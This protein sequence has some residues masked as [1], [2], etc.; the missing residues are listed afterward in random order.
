MQHSSADMSPDVARDKG[1]AVFFR[2]SG[3]AWIR[4]NIRPGRQILEN[5]NC[6]VVNLPL[7]R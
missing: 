6:R 4:D 7:S 5:L 3:K 1:D 2:R